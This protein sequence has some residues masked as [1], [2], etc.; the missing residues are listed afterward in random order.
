MTESLGNKGFMGRDATGCY[1]ILADA[2]STNSSCKS[3]GYGCFGTLPNILP[4]FPWC[5]ITEH[6]QLCGSSWIGARAGSALMR[7]QRET[8]MLIDTLPRLTDDERDALDGGYIAMEGVPALEPAPRRFLTIA[9]IITAIAAAI[10]LSAC[11]MTPTQ[12]KWAGIAAGVLIVGAIA[13]HDADSGGNASPDVQT[14]TV[15]CPSDPES[16]R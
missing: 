1:M 7:H 10:A 5:R 2:A 12:K 3:V 9:K 11:A 6:P 14:P 8:F 13:A 16:C 4:Y 15:P